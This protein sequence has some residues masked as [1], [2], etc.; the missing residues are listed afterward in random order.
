[1][2]TIGTLAIESYITVVTGCAAICADPPLITGTVTTL[3]NGQ[4]DGTSGIVITGSRNLILRANKNR[5]AGFMGIS[6]A[7][8]AELIGH[9]RINGCRPYRGRTVI[10]G[11]NAQQNTISINL[12]GIIA[13][14]IAIAVC[15]FNGNHTLGAG[16]GGHHRIPWKQG[17]Y[18]AQ[19]QYHAQ[20]QR[21]F[22][23]WCPGN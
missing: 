5:K 21:N 4:N 11:G 20:P 16:S 10:H 18:H 9:M 15:Q 8:P 2:T 12:N 13:P 7:D 19:T 14:S 6:A 22:T 3:L 1:M 17:Q 23:A